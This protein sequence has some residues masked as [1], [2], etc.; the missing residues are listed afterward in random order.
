MTDPSNN[1]GFFGP[2]YDYIKHIRSPSQMQLAVSG[3][4]WEFGNDIAAIGDYIA[5][6]IAGPSR[7]NIYPERPLGMSYM[8]PTNAKCTDINADVSGSM[9]QRSIFVN[10]IPLGNIP[11]LT[12]AADGQ[13]FTSFRG[14]IPGIAQNLEVLN[15]YTF[16]KGLLGGGAP[17]CMKVT[18]PT[19]DASGIVKTN[20]GYVTIEDL[21]DMDPCAVAQVS[22]QWKNFDKRTYF[23]GNVP[24]AVGGGLGD[25]SLKSFT[26]GQCYCASK[27]SGLVPP[28]G[29]TSGYEGFTNINK[30]HPLDDLLNEKNFTELWIII[31]SII[32]L[33]IL[34]K[35]CS[36]QNKFF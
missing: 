5:V 13:D 4:M 28:P 1:Y 31:I 20:T 12:S 26:E 14:L 36:K 10:N 34:L 27:D 30:Q 8:Q 33:Y 32:G 35:V 19:I 16:A 23:N 22:N 17:P 29:M 9:V 21:T 3:N 25:G 24:C 15:P 18:L 2:N 6:L 11:L 7:A